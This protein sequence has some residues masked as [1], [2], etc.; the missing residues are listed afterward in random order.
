M[1]LFKTEMIF[2]HPPRT[3]REYGVRALRYGRRVSRYPTHADL[4]RLSD[5]LL[6]TDAQDFTPAIE[7]PVRV[8]RAA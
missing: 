3:R 5:G 1:Q 8:D 6:R 4:P 2:L 7:T